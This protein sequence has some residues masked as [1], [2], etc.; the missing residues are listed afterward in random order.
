MYW[1]SEH[2]VLLC[3]EVVSENP[4]KTRKGSSQRSEIW[5]RIANTLNTCSK[6]VFAVDKRSVRDHVGILINRI[7]KKLRAEERSSGIAPPEPTELENLVEEIMALEETADAEM[8]DDDES[9]KGKAVGE[10]S[11]PHKFGFSE[12]SAPQS[13]LPSCMLVLNLI[14]INVLLS[15][16]F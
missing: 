3:R 7:K 2:D 11:I 6:P 14:L 10:I 9:V 15:F 4:F 13:P 1:T 16:L 5:D 12:I 8:R